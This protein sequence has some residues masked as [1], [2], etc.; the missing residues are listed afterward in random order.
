MVRERDIPL[1]DLALG[2]ACGLP[3]RGWRTRLCDIANDDLAQKNQ[4]VVLVRNEAVRDERLDEGQGCGVER[5]GVG[6]GYA[7][8]DLVRGGLE[9]GREDRPGFLRQV[10]REFVDV[11][12]VEAIR[13]VP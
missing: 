13:G 5:D 10:G 7:V 4:R 1:A 2:R 12:I 9:R 6:I 11:G 8:P 3:H